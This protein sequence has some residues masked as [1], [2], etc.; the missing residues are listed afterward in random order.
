M[1]FICL[2]RLSHLYYHDGI[3]AFTSWISLS[4]DNLSR[5]SLGEKQRIQCSLWLLFP[6][7]GL[8]LPPQTLMTWHTTPAYSRLSDL[9]VSFSWCP[10]ADQA[11]WI[12]DDII[13]FSAEKVV[14]PTHTMALSYPLRLK[15]PCWDAGKS[16]G[17][18]AWCWHSTVLPPFW[19]CQAHLPSGG[20]LPLKLGI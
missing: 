3:Y 13:V 14:P 1:E 15:K 4:C 16:C 19:P 17:G 10:Q 11:A 5:S 18:G 9:R 7:W 20:T 6:I 12:I 8:I 2:M